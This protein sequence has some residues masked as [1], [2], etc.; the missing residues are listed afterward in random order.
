MAARVNESYPYMRI[1]KQWGLPYELVLLYAQW[2]MSG[3][4]VWPSECGYWTNWACNQIENL[5][6]TPTMW[7]FEQDVQAAVADFRRIQREGW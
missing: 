3:P 6:D 2:C 1:A 5:L 7:K 4:A